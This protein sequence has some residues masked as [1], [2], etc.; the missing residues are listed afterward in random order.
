MMSVFIKTLKE[1]GVTVYFCDREADFDIVQFYSWAK[2]TNNGNG[3]INTNPVSN[4]N[5]TT[6]TVASVDNKGSDALSPP[7]ERGE[8]SEE[9]VSTST[10]APTILTPDMPVTLSIA[11]N[12][13]KK[14]KNNDN[15]SDSDNNDK[16]KKKSRNVP[17]QWVVLAQDSD[18]CAYPDL[19]HYLPISEFNWESALPRP[20]A[21]AKRGVHGIESWG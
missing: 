10:A 13:N 8:T 7:T 17:F 20:S 1:N 19:D 12:N 14:K 5:E 6:P 18:Y 15:N 4:A 9:P 21:G 3:N 2:A 11:T 16:E